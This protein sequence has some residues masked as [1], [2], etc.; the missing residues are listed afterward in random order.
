VIVVGPDAALVIVGLAVTVVVAWGSSISIRS[1][2]RGP[3]WALE[4]LASVRPVVLG[5][6]AAGLVL[7]FLVRPLWVGLA[8]LYVA[9][10]VLLLAATL[11]RALLRLEEAGGLDELPIER[12]RQI[13]RRART[14]ILAAGVVLAAIGVGGSVAGAGAVAWV[15]AILG[16]ALVVTALSLSAEQRSEE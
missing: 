2:A 13:V 12:R 7:T 4:H 1:A 9:L 10:T 3:R 14:L 16:V 5:G 15:P 11:R 6:I 8:V